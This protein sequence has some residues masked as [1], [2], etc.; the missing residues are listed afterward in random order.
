MQIFFSPTQQRHA[1][2]TFLLR[3]RLVESPE[4]A[5]RADALLAAARSAGHEVVQPRSFPRDA[6][7]AVHRA[8]YLAF[9]ETGY[10]AWSGLPNAAPEITPNIHPNRHMSRRPH[11]IVGLAGWYLADTGTP[12]GP[13]TW[14]AS[15]AAAD[16]A[17][18]AC[19]AVMA[20]APV[21]YALC[22]PPGHHAYADMAG[23][24][25]FLNNAAIAAE[26]ARR[27]RD[28]VAILDVDVHHG[29]GTQGI[30]YER[31]DVLFASLHGDPAGFYPF[32]AGYAEETGAGPGAGF[33][34]NLPLA[35]GSGD[36]VYMQAL[37]RALGRIRSYAP[38][39][40]VV[41]LGLDASEADPLGVLK[42]STTGFERIAGAIAGLG[43]PTVLV[44][45]GGYL[46]SVLGANL[47][48]FL[49]GFEAAGG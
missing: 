20:G 40:L 1:P 4:R 16:T 24:F 28:R 32:Y 44:Q 5:E 2:K 45:E 6:V 9:L 10:S 14:V 8:D 39:L 29:N 49:A 17:L 33:T 37:A 27:R 15:L 26:H 42:I 47:A 18:A 36:E 38:G 30:F 21:A 23:G 41:S 22:R 46:S 11:G 12:I 35:H 13:E 43:L 48:A 19:E 3:G 25:C 7:A 31:A 34:M